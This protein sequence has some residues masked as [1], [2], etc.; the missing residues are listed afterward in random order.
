L[1]QPH[2]TR[3]DA[4]ATT[5]T[6]GAEGPTSESAPTPATLY[7]AK[8][9]PDEKGSITTQLA[10]CR[11]AA[12]AEGRE[13]VAEYQD[14]NASGYTGNRGPGLAAAM[15][16]AERTGGEL[17]VQHT[18]RLGRGDGKQAKHLVQ[19]VLWAWEAGVGLRSVQDDDACDDLLYAV[20]HG[21]RNHED[22]ARKSAATRAGLKRRK[23]RGAPV[24]RIPLGYRVETTVIDGQPVT[25]RV[26]DPPGAALVER[27]FALVE[28]GSTFGDVARI[29]N[30]EGIRTRPTKARPNGSPWVSKSL[31]VIIHNTAYKAERGYPEIIDADRFDRIH[32]GLRRLDPVM[33]AKR[34]RGRKP[35]DE[36]YFLRSILRCLACGSTLYARRYAA[37]RVYV[38]RHRLL[39]SGV[40][41]APA[42]PAELIEDHVLRH[43]GSFV[44]S[45]EGFL[46]ERV[47]ERDSE[48][49]VREAA[50]KRQRAGLTDLDR[51]RER[52]LAEY[53][54]LVAEG[55]SVARIALEEVQRIDGERAEQRRLIEEA[56]AVIGE[57]SG[58][59]D[60]DA[61][62]DYYAALVD[63]VHGRIAKA[64]GARELNDA[65]ST[66]IA[67]LWA[68]IETDRER[69]LVEF[70][71]VDEGEPTLPGGVP[72]LP[73]LRRRPTLP[74]RLL[75]DPMEPEPLRQSRSQTSV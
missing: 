38:C 16:H 58:P 1:T 45:V 6:E 29:L 30:S 35:S 48:R 46:A 22:S 32:A 47:N 15:E 74:P 51:Q 68:E 3:A 41:S 60:L 36:S 27:I 25:S 62:L 13:V 23:D 33:V 17:W 59:P 10:D 42:I 52:H 12:E 28:S 2:S 4:P 34:K 26:I 53:R 64:D 43:L 61:A 56:E 55:A 37:G 21:Q 11:A 9:S 7:G 50:L 67:G 18:D 8:S 49:K 19:H 24:G 73:E 71:L 31:S 63:H 75:D 70:A 14:E 57:W 72:I 44:D 39:G 54:E 69:L 66:I 5:P 65:L 40:C 20:V